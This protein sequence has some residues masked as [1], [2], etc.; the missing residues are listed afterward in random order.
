MSC[1]LGGEHCIS[2]TIPRRP[3]TS[4]DTALALRKLDAR[5]STPLLVQ[6]I[7]STDEMQMRSLSASLSESY[8]ILSPAAPFNTA[9]SSAFVTPLPSAARA[10]HCSQLFLPVF[11]L[12]VHVAEEVELALLV[13]D[14][15]QPFEDCPRGLFGWS[16][17]VRRRREDLAFEATDKLANAEDVGKFADCA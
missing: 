5:C 3:A 11:D 4:G 1:G 9:S 2:R 10:T 6:P 7:P 8:S 13:V 15:V 14:L 17:F 12:P 16:R